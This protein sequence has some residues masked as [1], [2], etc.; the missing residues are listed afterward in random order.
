MLDFVMIGFACIIAYD[1][2]RFYFTQWF[3]N[4]KKNS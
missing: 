2:A 3:T 1:L 4:T